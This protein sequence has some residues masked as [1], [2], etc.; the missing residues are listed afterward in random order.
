VG[1]KICHESF[2]RIGGKSS[3]KRFGIQFSSRKEI[4]GIEE[5]KLREDGLSQRF[6]LAGQV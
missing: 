1:D 2:L 5:L 6:E 4:W 3:A